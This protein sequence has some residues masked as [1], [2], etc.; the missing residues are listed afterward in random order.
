MEPA[1]TDISVTL[2]EHTNFAV[3]DRAGDMLPGSYHGFFVGDTRVLSLLVLRLAGKRLEPLASGGEDHGAGTFYLAN[4]RLPGVPASTIAVFRD[5]RVSGSLEERIRLISYAA[6]PLELDLT[7]EIDTDFADIF[8][9]RGRSQLRRRIRKRHRPQEIRFVYEHRGYRRATTVTLDRPA[10]ATDG[11]IT[12][13]ITLERG[14]PWD[15]TLSVVS[16]QTHR[17]GVV[18][19]PPPRPLNPDRVRR[20]SGS[21][22]SLT[23][24]DPRLRRTW[25]RAV[26]DLASLLLTGPAGNFIPAAGLPWFLAIFG[27]DSA[28]T[29]MQSLMLGSQI[30]Y[31]T[32]RQLGLYQGTTH[33][34]F[35]DEEPGKIPHEVRT[36]ELATLGRIPFGR[37]YGSVDSTPLYVMLY[38]AACR[39]SGWLGR[40]RARRPL[41][42]ALA[43]FLPMVEAAMAWIEDRADADGLIWY[44]RGRRGG[45]INQVWK[46]SNTSMRY[47]DGRNAVPSIAAVEVQGYV[48]AAR[49]GMAEIYRALGRRNDAAAQEQAA[50]RLANVIESAFWMPDEGTY[51]LGLDQQRRQIDGVGS[52]AG[53]LLWA[54]AASPERAA[55]VSE[56]LMA[57]D[58]FSGW[59]IRTLSSRNPGYNPIGYHLGAVWPHDNSLIAD[60]MARSGQ[61]GPAA[62]V[63]DAM[64]DA[65]DADPRARLPELF[66]GFDR[67]ATP[68]LVPYPTACA[69][70]A[71]AT[72]AI[73]QFVETILA[74]PADGRPELWSGL[75]VDGGDTHRWADAS[76][77]PAAQPV[78]SSTTS[79]SRPSTR[80]A[81]GST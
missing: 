31:G 67:A 78:K 10:T 55:Q 41:P 9:V 4:P 34:A 63:I 53:H 37:Y 40:G 47:A 17:P 6:E 62:R 72:G 2:V 46:D 12:L 18:P 69:P 68:D 16:Q 28:I 56:R 57:P 61:V 43:E 1:T 45:I 35:R 14:R 75:T 3:S 38:V 66:A 5:R 77:D 39:R 51:A 33:D 74:M 58:L 42:A 48:V 20:W 32:L 11:R 60:G 54:G 65:A 80:S 70:Q 44:H 25:Y 59:G 29:A 19:P 73:F 7:I 22:P 71:W 30:P 81:M 52:N 49:R 21:L 64:L 36:G 76:A 27:R 79:V 13:P 24:H 50:D 26:R 8:E 15:L 23:T